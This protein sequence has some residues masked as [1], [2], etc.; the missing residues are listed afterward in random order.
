M[1]G[2]RCPAGPLVVYQVPV[3]L[4]VAVLERVDVDEPER[5]D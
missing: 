5:E 2:R 3:Q 1:P 4:A